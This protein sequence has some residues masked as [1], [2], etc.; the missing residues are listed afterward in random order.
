MVI[1]EGNTIGRKEKDPLSFDKLIFGSSTIVR[2]YKFDN[3]L[4]C[5]F[6][7]LFVCIGVLLFHILFSIGSSSTW[8][9][10]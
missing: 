5:V 4:K 2:P 6:A 7:C 1:E 3:L 10:C 8:Y 9:Y